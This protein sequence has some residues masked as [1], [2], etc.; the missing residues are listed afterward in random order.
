MANPSQR[1]CH[2]TVGVS[3]SQ[4]GEP[5]LLERLGWALEQHRFGTHRFPRC[6]QSPCRIPY[7]Q[8]GR[9]GGLWRSAGVMGLV[10]QTTNLLQAAGKLYD[11]MAADALLLLTETDL[12]WEAVRA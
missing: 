8:Q 4:A 6:T 1:A 11:E 10:A 7:T 3:G 12:D 5:K 2:S 9:T